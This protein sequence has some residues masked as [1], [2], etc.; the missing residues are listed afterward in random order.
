MKCWTS[1][2]RPNHDTE[3]EADKGSFKIAVKRFISLLLD[4]RTQSEGMF[5]FLAIKDLLFLVTEAKISLYVI[6]I[7]HL[8]V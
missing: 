2:S 6:K 5:D 8:P 7:C 3:A 4:L 1:G